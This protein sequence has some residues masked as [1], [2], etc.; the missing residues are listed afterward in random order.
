MARSG[1]LHLISSEQLEAAEREIVDRSRR[2]DFY[3]TEYSVELLAQ[4]M[5]EGDFVIPEYQRAFTWEPQRKSRFIESLIMGLPIPFLFFW[6]MESGKLEI[7]DGSQRL[8]TLHEYILGGFELTS[9]EELPSLSGTRFSDLSESRQRK[10]R[11]RSIRGIVLNEHADD[12]A[13]FDMFERI[14]TGSKVANT[15]EV[16]RGALRGPFQDLVI[17]LSKSPLLAEL[18]PVSGKSEKEKIPEELVSRFFA[19]GDGLDGYR[20]SPSRFIFD[21]TK[22]MNERMMQDVQMVEEYR[23]RFNSTLQFIKRAF[24]NGFRK[25]ASAS[26]TPRVRFEAI[27]IGSYLA[28]KDRPELYSEENMPDVT[29]WIDSQ[30]FKDVTTSDAANVRSKL[31]NRMDYV[32][33]ALLGAA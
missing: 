12:Q 13:R 17:E 15:A 21:Y 9:L 20:D 2:I 28:L 26:T 5:G 24:P 22:M 7:V 33:K 8:R 30:D 32:R 10:I 27:A 3:M 31:Y 25:S 29:G 1:K 16:R 23:E 19:Y 11:N 18:A 6:E 14:N 4:K